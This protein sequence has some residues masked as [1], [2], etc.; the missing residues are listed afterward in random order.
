MK[1]IHAQDRKVCYRTL[2]LKLA[3]W[4]GHHHLP[5]RND[6]VDIHQIL[7]GEPI[8]NKL[9]QDIVRSIYRLNHC[10]HLDDWVDTEIVFDALGEIR[11]RLLD[12]TS[13]DIDQINLLEEMGWAMRSLFSTI[14]SMPKQRTDKH[15]EGFSIIPQKVI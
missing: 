2:M 12:H 6:A 5:I 14:D 8:H 7:E 11:E 3:D 15:R 9:V 13:T 1:Q 10:N 4:V